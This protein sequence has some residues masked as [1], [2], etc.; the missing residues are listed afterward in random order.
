MATQNIAQATWDLPA[1]GSGTRNP[2][3]GLARAFT[4]VVVAPPS[5]APIVDNFDPAPGSGLTSIN[6]AVAFDARDPDSNLQRVFI[7]VSF[8]SSTGSVTHKELIWDG[9]EFS[10]RYSLSTRVSIPTGHRYTCR[11]DKGW[12][13]NFVIDGRAIDTSGLEA[14]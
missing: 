9:N 2:R 11:R 5:T 4:P 10:P 13:A 6:D 7:F 1:V 8:L 14:L 12:T 3:K